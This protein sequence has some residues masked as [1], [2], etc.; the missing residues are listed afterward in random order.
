MRRFFIAGNWKMN[1]TRQDGVALVQALI[2]GA[3]SATVTVDVLVAPPFPY[4]I[5]I[6]EAA[7]G[8]GIVVGAQNASPEAPGAF[9]GEVAL[10]MLIDAGVKSVILGHSERRQFYGDTDEIINRKVIATREKGL[11]AIFCV[12]ELLEER[13]GNQTEA[14]LDRQLEG[15][16]KG[17]SAEQLSDVV[18]AYEPVWAIGTG[19][20]A[21][22]EQAETAHAHIRK[23][24]ETRY[25]SDVANAT[26]ILYGG[27]VKANNAQALLSQ[28]N[29]DGALV[30]GASL[31]AADF[32][33]I[34]EA[35][36][37]LSK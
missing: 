10:D 26:R 2:E 15:G 19:L 6:V 17:V 36:V 13:Q 31:K 37:S 24:L 27:S 7:A 35:G 12:G 29:V 8:S 3:K 5:P 11:Q 28:P 9:T 25:T 33:P 18:I 14:V 20:T 16:L 22:P 21:S 1:T 34:I 4:L 23:W 32:L 30:G